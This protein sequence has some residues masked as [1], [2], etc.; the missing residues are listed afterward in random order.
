M[1]SCLDWYYLFTH[2]ASQVCNL[3]TNAWQQIV[4]ITT[5]AWLIFVQQPKWRNT[6]DFVGETNNIK[7]VNANK[8]VE[9][10]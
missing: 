4:S 9:S 3:T 7:F 10:L 5:N 2:L 8:H 6:V 1:G